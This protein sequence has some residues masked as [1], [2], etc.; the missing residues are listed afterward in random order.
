M[1]RVMMAAATEINDS[2]L[3]QHVLEEILLK[4]PYRSLSR[5][6]CVSKFWNSL[7]NS[8]LFIPPRLSHF[9]KNHPYDRSVILNLSLPH[10][11]QIF[12]HLKLFS[13]SHNNSCRPV[14]TSCTDTDIF[15]PKTFNITG[16]C[17][18]I[19][20]LTILDYF[21]I[22]IVLYNPATSQF[23]FL[24][25]SGIRGCIRLSTLGVG[26]GYDSRRDDYKVV[27]IKDTGLEEYS[28]NTDS[29][30][31]LNNKKYHST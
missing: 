17:N 28:L 9:I 10:H 25:D 21:D 13:I 27:S 7:L 11:E 31:S 1:K 5:F 12:S 19:I 8:P 15:K 29:W 24:P 2:N 26:M 6:R 16:H 22:D 20:C 3:P 18:G 4:V 23:K 14:D 30:R